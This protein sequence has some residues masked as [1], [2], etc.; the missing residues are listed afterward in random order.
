M[1]TFWG[2]HPLSVKGDLNFIGASG[3]YCTTHPD[4][5][6]P[7]MEIPMNPRS[8]RVMT[9]ALLS[10][11]FAIAA[12]SVSRAQNEVNNA[13]NSAVRSAVT[14]ARD[15]AFRT[16]DSALQRNLSRTNTPRAHRH[17]ARRIAR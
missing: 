5:R 12:T 2:D 6:T 9:V 4:P 14:D 11:A 15:A 17:A 16:R 13:S 1:R 10:V 8:L 7:L 3:D